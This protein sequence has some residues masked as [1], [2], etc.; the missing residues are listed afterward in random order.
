MGVILG[1]IK[2]RL[3][4]V[5]FLN[6]CQTNNPMTSTHSFLKFP[7]LVRCLC[8]G[9]SDQGDDVDFVVKA[10]HKLYVQGL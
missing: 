8:V 10:A 9:L 2:S 1:V 4:K 6:V 5:D 3:N 7:A